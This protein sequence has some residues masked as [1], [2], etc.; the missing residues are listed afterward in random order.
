M[1]RS[2]A[3]LLRILLYKVTSGLVKTWGSSSFCE[4]GLPAGE[5]KEGWPGVS[6]KPNNFC[7]VSLF[8][9]S[10]EFFHRKPTANHTEKQMSTFDA[11]S[12]KYEKWK[13]DF[14]H[15]YRMFFV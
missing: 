7:G 13:G 10:K 3:I 12:Q 4:R 9:L 14:E 6:Y 11:F 8:E 15:K 2:R 1:T 5:E